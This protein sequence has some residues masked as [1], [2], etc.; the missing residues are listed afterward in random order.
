[1]ILSQVILTRES[2]TLK[3]D[4]LIIAFIYFGFMKNKVLNNIHITSF[5]FI[6]L[7]YIILSFGENN[8]GRSAVYRASVFC[9]STIISCS[10]QRMVSYL[11]LRH[12]SQKTTLIKSIC[13]SGGRQ[14]YIA[15]TTPSII[16]TNELYFNSL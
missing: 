5:Y 14:Y 12:R 7:I 13:Q 3:Q 10:S 2:L 6:S 15:A 8:S 16:D 1:M 11:M 9:R 4:T